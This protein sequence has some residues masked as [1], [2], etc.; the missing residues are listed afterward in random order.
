MN[1]AEYV[2]T[3]VYAN[4]FQEVS[5]CSLTVCTYWDGKKQG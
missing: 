4:P 3:G 5:T 1:E 2:L